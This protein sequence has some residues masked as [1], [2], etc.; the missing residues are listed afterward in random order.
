[1]LPPLRQTVPADALQELELQKA[2]HHQRSPTDASLVVILADLHAPVAQRALPN[3][4]KLR[5]V[6]PGDEL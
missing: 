4:S 1:M 2:Q 3:I 6:S 5:R